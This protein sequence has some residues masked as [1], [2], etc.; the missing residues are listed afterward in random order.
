[1]L[2]QTHIVQGDEEDLEGEW[3]E[4]TVEEG[5]EEGEEEVWEEGEEGERSNTFLWILPYL[6]F[7]IIVLVAKSCRKRQLT[8]YVAEWNRFE[9]LKNFLRTKTS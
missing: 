5:M 3:G 9:Q 7:V 6:C 8:S 4:F 1:M 2:N